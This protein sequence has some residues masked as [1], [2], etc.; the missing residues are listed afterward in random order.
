MALDSTVFCTTAELDRLLSSAG[1]ISFADHDASGSSDTDVVE[2]CINQ[3]TAEIHDRANT[4]YSLTALAGSRTINR[5][6]VVMS[7]YFLCM[8][9]GN[10]IPESIKKEFDRITDL[11]DG[12]LVLLSQGTYLLAGVP[13]KADFGPSMSNITINRAYPYRKQRVTPNSRPNDT[14]TTSQDRERTVYPI[15]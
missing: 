11:R 14:T 1:V 4:F 7:A 12:L 6:C 13:R 5:W 15:E 9:R 3:A 10:P 8:R 2:D